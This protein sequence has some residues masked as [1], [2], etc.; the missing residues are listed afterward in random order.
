MGTPPGQTE[1]AITQDSQQ[2]SMPFPMSSP[3]SLPQSQPVWTP[4]LPQPQQMELDKAKR[5]LPEA[6]P[7]NPTRKAIASQDPISPTQPFL[8]STKESPEEKRLRQMRTF[9][10]DDIQHPQSSSTSREKELETALQ[11]AEEAKRF[12]Q[13]QHQAELESIQS[14]YG[15]V[16]DMYNRRETQYQSYVSQAKGMV[17]EMMQNKD[18]ET[19]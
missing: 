19:K 15:K 18:D 9:S 12:L 6:T 5:R 7:S 17:T 16:K 1:E 11:T 3:P 8:P 13:E 10:P 14:D 2:P 4:S